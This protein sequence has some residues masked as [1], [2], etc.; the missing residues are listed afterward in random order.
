MSLPIDNYNE[1]DIKTNTVIEQIARALISSKWMQDNGGSGCFD[2]IT[3]AGQALTDTSSLKKMINFKVSEDYAYVGY[4]EVDFELTQRI[5]AYDKNGITN[6]TGG[7]IYYF[8]DSKT[9]K[10]IEVLGL[11]MPFRDNDKHNW[12]WQMIFIAAAPTLFT[13]EWIKFSN[14]CERVSHSIEPDKKVFVIGG[15]IESFIPTVSW[16][17]IILPKDLKGKI[18]S[19]VDNFFKKGV[20]VYI[21]RNLK[22]FRKFLFA[23]PPGTGKTMICT[24]I[25]KKAIE[26][27]YIVIYLSSAQKGHGDRYGSTFDKIEY[28]LQVAAESEYPCVIILEEIDAYLHDDEKALILNVLDGN[29]SPLSKYGTLLIATTNYPEAIDDRI[30]K[31]PGR[32][33]R[34]Y[35]IPEVRVEEDVELLLKK[36]I[37]DMWN[38]E[39]LQLVPKLIGYPGAFIREV[40]IAA[41]TQCVSDDLTVLEYSM[42]EKAF[43]DLKDQIDARDSFLS[44][45]PDFKQFG[46][47]SNSRNGL[48]YE[49]KVPGIRHFPGDDPIIKKKKNS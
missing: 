41:V 43:Y 25:A 1:K 15:K 42:L 31:R 24:A 46:D 28:A 10:V 12:E 40:A 38:E 29:E 8:K 37:A 26:D 3:G 11:G 19:D 5:N 2:L 6:Q 39:H 34:I 35:I 4:S 49:K 47:I 21:D 13:Q 23:G 9:E 20:Q 30:L 14:E 7:Y 32:L 36:Y 44:G 48:G 33:D 27:G 17:D 45:K 18:Q 22:P 16:E